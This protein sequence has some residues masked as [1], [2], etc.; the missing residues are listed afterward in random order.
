MDNKLTDIAWAIRDYCAARHDCHG[1]PFATDELECR[2]N[3][4]PQLWGGETSVAPTEAPTDT[5]TETVA[6]TDEP[7]ASKTRQER[8]L[9]MFPHTVKIMAG[10]VIVI[11]LCPR[12]LGERRGCPA[13]YNC[14]KC[15]R[16]FWF[17]EEDSHD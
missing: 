7:T 13:D 15:K 5:P 11:D 12:R 6:P 10:D 8:F 9:E 16:E 17:A 1:C 3:G 4:I 14:E 2:I